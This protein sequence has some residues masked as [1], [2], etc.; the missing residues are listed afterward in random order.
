MNTVRYP[1]LAFIL[2]TVEFSPKAVKLNYFAKLQT[3]INNYCLTFQ[4]IKYVLKT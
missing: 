2:I 4:F 1:I 3:K